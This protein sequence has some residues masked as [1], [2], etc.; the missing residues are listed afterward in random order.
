MEDLPDPNE[1]EGIKLMGDTEQSEPVEDTEHKLLSDL[2]LSE[3]SKKQLGNSPTVTKSHF[4]LAPG[5]PTL[6]KK[7]CSSA[8]LGSKICR[9]GRVASK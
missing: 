1:L 5:L 6:S 8:D 9:N 7:L 3:S 4:L 2:Q